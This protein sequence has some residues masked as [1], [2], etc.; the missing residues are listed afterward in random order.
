MSLSHEARAERREAMAQCAAARG[1]HAAAAEF[2]VTT[3]TVSVACKEFKVTPLRTQSNKTRAP[4]TSFAMLKRLLD[5]KSQVEIAAEFKVQR[6][7]VNQIAQ[8]A[9]DAGIVLP[10]KG[11]E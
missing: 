2:K 3:Q 5:G 8:A 4:K 11:E 6:Q 10:K 7:R 9:L 1:V